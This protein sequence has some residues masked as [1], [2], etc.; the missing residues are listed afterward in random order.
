MKSKI[1]SFLAMVSLAANAAMAQSNAPAII[2]AP[3]KISVEKGADGFT[4]VR[5]IQIVTDATSRQTGEWLAGQL[6]SSTGFPFPTTVTTANSD[7]A[8]R[9]G[10]IV[11]TA[12]SAGASLAAEGYQLKVAP[13]V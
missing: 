5:A 9:K 6:R 7:S 13:D 1:I 11:L 2:P 12:A 4:L 10:T 8:Y 3:Q